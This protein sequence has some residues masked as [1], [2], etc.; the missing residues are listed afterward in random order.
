MV[1]V[2]AEKK[3]KGSRVERIKHVHDWPI[4]QTIVINRLDRPDR[5]DHISRQLGILNIPYERIDAFIGDFLHDNLKM[6]AIE[7][8]AELGAAIPDIPLST[9]ERS[10]INRNKIAW[11][12][13]H[14]TAYW[15]AAKNVELGL[16]PNGPILILEDD[17]TFHLNFKTVT[18]SAVLSLTE[19]DP[20]WGL[21]G[22]YRFL[23][24]GL[25]KTKVEGILRSTDFLTSH[26]MIIRDAE[27]SRMMM[28]AFNPGHSM[29]P[30]Y[31]WHHL[32]RGTM[33]PLRAYVWN[34]KLIACQDRGRFGS[35]NR[36]LPD[37]LPYDL[38]SV[39]IQEDSVITPDLK[40]VKPLKKKRP[41]N[42]SI[43]N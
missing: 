35:D 29:I 38:P 17:V 9:L 20:K 6:D 25:E 7:V 32:A 23:A 31:S 1:T 39:Q 18:T 19:A 12:L 15:K 14:M 33:A 42:D 27:T 11:A 40:Q 24:N 4:A 36:E 16:A 30:D 37:L 13:S 41:C 43:E 34:G 26:A 5:M 2:L 22:L 10:G 3:I 8:N 21:F 28:D